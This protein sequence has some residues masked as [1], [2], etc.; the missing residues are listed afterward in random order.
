MV[1]NIV[2]K[3]TN[4][5][6]NDDSLTIDYGHKLATINLKKKLEHQ[7]FNDNKNDAAND[8]DIDIDIISS[9]KTDRNHIIRK[10]KQT[11]SLKG[12][13]ITCF[14]FFLNFLINYKMTM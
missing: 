13:L 5:D 8:C 2:K 1:Q 12:M 3:P 14:F 4:D 10:I 6:N 11:F 7:I 9:A